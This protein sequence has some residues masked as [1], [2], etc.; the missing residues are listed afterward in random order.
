M[1]CYDT[2]GSLGIQLKNGECLLRDYMV[3]D[4]VGDDFADGIYVATEGCVVIY[5]G[6][7][8]AEILPDAV[9]D[10][11]GAPIEIDVDSRNPLAAVLKQ[12]LSVLDEE[13]PKED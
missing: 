4:K 3:G 5:K 13:N 1:G 6:K 9:F 7:F 2:F 10:K 12:Y 11:W 8:V